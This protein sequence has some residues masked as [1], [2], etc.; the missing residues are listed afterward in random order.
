MDNHEYLDSLVYIMRSCLRKQNKIKPEEKNQN[1]VGHG[2]HTKG[3]MHTGGI[4][5]PKT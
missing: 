3:R 1:I 5:K 4:G 2:S